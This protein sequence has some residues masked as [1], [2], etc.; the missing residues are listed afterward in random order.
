VNYRDGSASQALFNGPR[1]L[2]VAEDGTV[3]VA[4]SG[5]NRIRKID[6]Q[7]FFSLE[8]HTDHLV[9]VGFFCLFG[10][11][12]FASL[13]F[14]CC[15]CLL[16]LFVVFVCCVCFVCCVFVFV[17]FQG[18]IFF[19]CCCCMYVVVEVSRWRGAVKREATGQHC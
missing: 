15:V 4:D 9:L 17:F 11:F 18:F 6:P 1:G 19:R 10:L 2:A 13:C 14:V 5:N 12:V 16:C 7:G 8:S 3:F